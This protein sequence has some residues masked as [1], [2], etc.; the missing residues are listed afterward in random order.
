MLPEA[1]EDESMDVRGLILY[2][3]VPLECVLIV[4]GV[5]LAIVAA[6]CVPHVRRSEATPTSGCWRD[7]GAGGRRFIGMYPPPALAFPP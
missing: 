3:L 6:V 5:L 4:S 1:P 7:R 2:G